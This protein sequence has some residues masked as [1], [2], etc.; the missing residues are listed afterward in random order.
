[1]PEI[2]VPLA[3]QADQ[4]RDTALNPTQLVN[5]YAEQIGTE[6]FAVVACDGFA[7]WATPSGGAAGQIRGMLN[8]NDTYLYYVSGTRLQY[9]TTGAGVVHLAELAT[10]GHAYMARNRRG[11]DGV[12][13]PQVAVVTSDALFRIIEDN[14]VSTPSLDAEIP[15]TLFNSVCHID[16]YFVITMS[17]GEFY[18]TAIDDGTDIDVLDF[19]SAQANPDGLTR[20]LVR[21][22]ELV[23]MGP[24]S[25]EFWANTGATDFPFE[26][27]HAEGYGVYCPAAA[28]P[29]V[30]R[31]DGGMADTIIWP[32]SNSDG[33]F[34][35]VCMMSGYEARPISTSEV[36]RAIR[37]DA[38]PEDIRG[39]QYTRGDGTTFYCV[40]G[41]SF[42]YEYNIRT[43]F[44]HK[45]TSSGSRWQ[46]SDAAQFNGSTIFGD[47]DSA[48]LYQRSESITPG[49][50]S[51]VTMRHS[52]DHGDTWSTARSATIGT[53]S[54]RTSRARFN[55]LGLSGEDGKVF[56]LVVTNSV[57]EAG[58]AN[59]MTIITPPVSTYPNRLIV[60]AFY[61]DFIP[62]GS[63]ATRPK[64]IKRARALARQAAA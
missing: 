47:Y 36:D 20:G 53:S 35:G 57:Y 13:D 58:T 39:F 17:N 23:L 51:T 24:R 9:A 15:S 55:R 45:R 29:M 4:A 48:A 21:G 46:V 31:V 33:A 19:S 26:R 41:T 34:V 63:L 1:M 8:L 40:V 52:N 62:G 18:I 25:T 6:G 7:A 64:G 59:D 5:C 2:T 54:Q 12:G 61:V 38:A 44:W 22:R 28:V 37:A 60:D 43:G 3:A 10:S 27:A 30:A 42:A 14:I 50:A 49:S 32:A 11:A 16:G 56:E